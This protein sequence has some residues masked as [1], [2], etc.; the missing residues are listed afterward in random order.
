MTT[1]GTTV[2]LAWLRVRYTLAAHWRLLALAALL[3]VLA[4][5]LG[6]CDPPNGGGIPGPWRK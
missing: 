6:W 1:K 2:E 3:L 4:V 5:S